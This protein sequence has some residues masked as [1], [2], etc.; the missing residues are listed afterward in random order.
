MKRKLSF[1]DQTDNNMIIPLTLSVMKDI[2]T[3]G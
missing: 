1:A 2:S 3:W